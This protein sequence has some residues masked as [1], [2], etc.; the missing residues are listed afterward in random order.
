MLLTDVLG[1]MRGV[2]VSADCS[3]GQWLSTQDIVWLECSS[4]VSGCRHPN[5]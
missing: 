5:N 1:R 3:R 4:N 2:T